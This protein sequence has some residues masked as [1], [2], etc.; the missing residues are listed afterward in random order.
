MRV[1]MS[2]LNKVLDIYQHS[3]KLIFL[4]SY[5]PRKCG[6]ATFTKDLT[7]AI[8]DLNPEYLVRI[9]AMNGDNGETYEYPPEV[10]FTIDKDSPESY[11][12]VAHEINRTDAEFVCLQH[13]YGLFG[14]S[15]GEYI[16]NLLE[17][18][19]RPIVTT[20]HTILR[21]PTREQRNILMRLAEV[22]EVIVTMLPNA[23]ECLEKV[24]GI[25]EEKVVVIH[26]G[27]ADQP[28]STQ[29]H[30]ADF[31][32]EG[33][34]VL[35]M[36]GLLNPNKGADYVIEALPAILKEFPET[37]FVLAG[38]THPGVLKWEGEKYRN[39]LR[40]RAEELGVTDQLV[41]VD[42]YL[43]LPELL[44][45]YE[46][47]DIYLT[48]HLD[49]QQTTSGTLAYALGLGKACISTPYTY[50]EEMLA[51]DRG[52]LVDFRSGDAIAQAVLKIFTNP[53]LQKDLE[54]HAYALGRQMSWPRVAERYLLLFRVIQKKYD[55]FS[56]SV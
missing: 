46:A 30:K 24:Y 38:E 10:L 49:A 9:A 1:R 39:G 16:F 3:I 14:G 19:N 33:K 15:Y 17:N 56:V 44:T 25:P 42:K 41:F 53:Q 55:L 36:T 43:P 40:Q 4:S 47:C 8:N 7:K 23:K 5:I 11:E 51:N 35:L 32:W 6:I 2:K 18:I 54:N 26:H 52:L 50:A 12:K 22:S 28:K 34:R 29:A 45:Y 27:V 20:V 13:E 48:P 37:L 21:E 31:G